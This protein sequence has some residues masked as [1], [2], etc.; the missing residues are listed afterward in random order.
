MNRLDQVGFTVAVWALENH[1]AGFETQLFGRI[2]A[3]IGEVKLGN[4]DVT[5]SQSRGY[6]GGF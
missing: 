3:E 6:T 2:V 4:V 1:D 5:A